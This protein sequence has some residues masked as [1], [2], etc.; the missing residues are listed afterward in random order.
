MV[1]H[2]T[3]EALLDAAVR[4]AEQ[5]GLLATSID[6]IVREA[7]VAKGT[8]YVHFADRGSF[9]VA[10]HRRFHDDLNAAI[11]AAAAR[12]PP[13]RARLLAAVDAYLDACLAASGVKAVLLEARTDP[14]VAVEI[15][16][17]NDATAQGAVEDFRALG[18]TSP[19]DSARLFVALVAEAA[20]VELEAGR[21]QPRIR[22]ALRE[23]L[24]MRSTRK[25]RAGVAADG[26]A[27]A[28]P[29]KR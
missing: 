9:L 15:G 14:A 19:A 16:R 20:L 8:F 25:P 27:H 10:I 26:G 11:S 21:R 22:T 1:S 13:G 2:P 29:A 28:N 17:R 6:E 3:R 12:L 7:G 24:P 18:A 23:Y 5:N 4:L